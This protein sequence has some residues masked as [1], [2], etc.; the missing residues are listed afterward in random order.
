MNG[1]SLLCH[2][3]ISIFRPSVA[4]LEINP[5]HISHISEKCENVSINEVINVFPNVEVINGGTYFWPGNSY[6]LFSLS[7]FSSS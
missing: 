3:Y 2:L 6:P 4:V 5:R 1:A 7:L